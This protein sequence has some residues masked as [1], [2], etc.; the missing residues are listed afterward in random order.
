MNEI[1]WWSL[2]LRRTQLLDAELGQPLAH[3][4]GLLEALAL[5]NSGTQPTGERITGTVGIMDLLLGDF[6][7][8]VLLDLNTACGR[9]SSHGGESSLCNDH[10]TGALSV[11]LL[12]GSELLGDFGD[13]SQTPAV[14]LRVSEGFG[15]VANKIV[16]VGDDAV[17][18][19]FE[20]LGD[21]GCREV[22]D[23]NLAGR[24]RSV[25]TGN[26]REIR[27]RRRMEVTGK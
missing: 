13:V 5:H 1:K 23:E 24:A 3:V 16:D 4:N 27:R 2:N 21:E 9:D 26:G 6:V 19:V 14:A 18:L 17:E 7:N 8:G 12:K 22:E 11:L 10:D 20:E 15:F 25:S